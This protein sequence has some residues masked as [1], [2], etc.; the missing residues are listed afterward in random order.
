M[1]PSQAQ[2]VVGDLIGCFPRFLGRRPFHL[3]IVQEVHED[4]IGRYALVTQKVK[5]RRK[6]PV[7]DVLSDGRFGVKAKRSE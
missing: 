7:N 1:S 3:R 2:D 5:V 4:Q 6:R